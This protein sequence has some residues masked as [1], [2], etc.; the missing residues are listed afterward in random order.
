ML[1]PL[2]TVAFVIATF[3]PPLAAQDARRP[4]HCI[5]IADAAPGLRYLHKAAWSDPIPDHAVRIH[6]IAHASFM[7]QTR[8]GL[9]AITDYSGFVGQTGL[10]PDI[11]TM[12]HAHSTHWTASPDPAIP[13][14]LQGWGAFGQGIEHHLD[15]GEMLVRNVSTDIRSQYGRAE[16]RG[17][18]I[19]VFEVEGLCI[20]HLGHLH[21]EP[22]DRQYAALGRLDV[23]M[24]PVDGGYTMGPDTTVKVVDRLKSRIIL[25]MHWFAGSALERFIADVSDRFAIDRRAGP[26][27]LVSLRD[28]PARP[29]VV[30]LRPEWLSD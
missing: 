6:Y 10:I 30:V 29:T 11:V 14:I 9:A 25:P 12:N 18:S 24:V 19:F 20:G 26:D 5:A 7:I 1:R 13:H 16:E 27:M 17:N 28:L 21:H 23:V 2:A 22:N 4:S 8:G 15:L 3:A